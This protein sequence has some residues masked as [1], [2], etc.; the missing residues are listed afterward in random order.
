M[1]VCECVHVCVC[2]CAC[3]CMCLGRCVCV[4]VCMCVF[5]C[6]CVCMCVC[7]CA[8]AR[9]GLC[10]CVCRMCV[11]V[12]AGPLVRSHRRLGGLR[13]RR[14]G[15]MLRRVGLRPNRLESAPPPCLCLD[16]PGSVC[17]QCV[18][19]HTRAYP[20]VPFLGRRRRRR[21]RRSRR[22][23]RRCCRR[24]SLHTPSRLT[25]AIA[26][27][28]AARAGLR[29]ILRMQMAWPFSPMACRQSS[30]IARDRPEAARGCA[31]SLG[32]SEYSQ[33]L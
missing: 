31:G 1:C 15:R 7:V 10:A 28:H 24:H 19:Q 14:S 29:T 17:L 27:A 2:V 3:V 16:W 20:R 5:V 22:R 4:C 11:C 12:C 23:S 9:M 6:I 30:A 8:C 33:I 25:R 21:R 13:C 18:P 32:Y 26:A